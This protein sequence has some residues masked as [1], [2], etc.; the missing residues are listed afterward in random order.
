MFKRFAPPGEEAMAFMRRLWQDYHRYMYYVAR[1][2]TRDA[3]SLE[4]IVS[5]SCLRLMERTDT[6]RA[7]EPPA[8]RAYIRRVVRSQ[9]V[10]QLRVRRQESPLPEDVPG[11]AE[12]MARLELAEELETL[13]EAVDR[14]P[15]A[16][17]R[18]IRLKYRDGMKGA[19][20]AGALG[21]AESTARKYLANAKRRL[22]AW[23]YDWEGE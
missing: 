4:D 7:L 18:A 10:N 2:Y 12:P 8:L 19:E 17:R 13:L 16:E 1:E 5:D 15:D 21:V 11:E 22:R 3:A 20:I 6:L 14:L 9:A 23:L